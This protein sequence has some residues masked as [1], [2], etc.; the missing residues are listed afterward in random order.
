MY[1]YIVLYC[2]EYN[3]SVLVENKNIYIETGLIT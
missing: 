3:E 2:Y 1:I